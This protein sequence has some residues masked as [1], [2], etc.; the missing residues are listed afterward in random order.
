MRE[1]HARR[2]AGLVLAV[3]SLCFLSGSGGC[4]ADVAERESADRS[5]ALAG[6]GDGAQP[7]WAMNA[8]IIEACSCPM[9]CQCYFDSKPA[10][11]GGHGHGHADAAADAAGGAEAPTHFCQFNNA[12]RVNKGHYGGTK[13]DGIKFWVGGD[14]G[15]DFSDGKMD[16]AVLTFDPAVTPQQREGVKAVLA[17]LYPVQWGSFTVAPDAPIEWKA[18]KDK[19]V[20]RLDAGKRAEVRLNRFPGMTDKPIVIHNLKYWGAPRNDGFVLMPNELEALRAAPEGQKPFEFKGT[21]GF[22]ITFDIRSDDVKGHAHG[23][24]STAGM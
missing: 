14:L 3:C 15:G 11:H 20:A 19:A 12:Y 17:H 23:E 18:D 8:T 2:A 7:S 22:M 9:F 16:W 6:R 21:N 4:T 13:L 5:T 1:S 24:K 10:A